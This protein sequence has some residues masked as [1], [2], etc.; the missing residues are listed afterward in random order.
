MYACEV[1]AIGEELWCMYAGGRGTVLCV[2]DT[3]FIC[4]S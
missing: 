3:S 1:V 4:I 2:L